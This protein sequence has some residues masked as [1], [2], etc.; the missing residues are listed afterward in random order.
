MNKN[1][2][3][4]FNEEKFISLKQASIISGYAKDYI[5]QLCRGEK[6]KAKKIGRDWFVNS[7]SLIS[8]KQETLRR[9]IF[10]GVEKK[11][12]A[13]KNEDIW[14]KILLSSE[15]QTPQDV[16]K[17]EISNEINQLKILS[18]VKSFFKQTILF[19]LILLTPLIILEF[20]FIKNPATVIA[21]LDNIKKITEQTIQTFSAEAD[22]LYLSINRQA[23]R[24]TNLIRQGSRKVI[25]DTLLASAFLRQ[26]TLNL[27]EQISGQADFFS[28]QVSQFVDKTNAKGKD[29]IADLLQKS[30]SLT[31]KMEE[32]SETAKIKI[33]P[34][35]AS[36][37]NFFS[38]GFSSRKSPS[39]SQ[40]ELS[41][42]ESLPK[43]LF[44][45]KPE[46]EKPKETEEEKEILRDELAPT[47]R[48]IYEKIQPITQITQQIIPPDDKQLQSIESKIQE[49]FAKNENQVKQ[50]A[51]MFQAFSQ[52]QRIN[53]L[54]GVTITNGTV[55]G[56]SGLTDA[57]VPNTITASNYLLL[58]G[59]TLTGALTGTSL[60][61]SGDLTVSGSQTFSGLQT[62][63]QASSTRLSVFDQIWIG[64]TSTTTLRGDGFAS[65]IPFA[66]TTALTVSNGAW[67]IEGNIGIGTTSPYSKLSVVGQI[68]AAYF[69]ATTSLF[70]TFPFASTTAL[71]VSGTASTTNL[72]VSGTAS[73]TFSGPLESYSGNFIIGSS[74]TSNNLLFNPY[75]G[76]VGIASSSP[77]ALLSINPDGLVG[78]SFLV[79]SSTQ[80]NLIVLNS[81]YVGIGT[82]TPRGLLGLND[83]AGLDSFIVGSS[84]PKFI[85]KDSGY[86]GIGTSTPAYALDIYGTLRIDPNNGLI[87]P[88]SSTPTL[89]IAGQI[90]ID[91]TSGQLK[92]YDGI[93]VQIVTG[94]TSPAFNIA[95]TTMG[96]NGKQFRNGTTSILLKNFPE[97]MTLNGFY[98]KAT[99][100]AASAYAG[101]LRFGDGTNWTEMGTCTT[102][103]VET[104]TIT[105]NTFTRFED[106]IVEAS[107][108]APET[109]RM[110]IT[111]I[112]EK[113]AD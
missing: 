34:K 91:T 95:S 105:N 48:T 20:V 86:I 76:K 97:A 89:N 56:L 57:D 72:I 21:S 24:Q 52:S 112:L 84:T 39:L 99:S 38:S 10:N 16:K 2:E 55:S 44:E 98:C 14:D 13:E 17:I 33:K 36:I 70:S 45:R 111:V 113:T 88:A 30:Q 109:D 27:P 12:S 75:G 43:T 63:S 107:S 81:G 102:S 82:S 92:W 64:G 50:S 8:Y 78:P 96:I 90:A 59:G 73:S 22:N 9:D 110:T 65:I 15:N 67:F 11:S 41:Q 19:F 77:W 47:E 6:I 5:G 35:I 85:I 49:L 46:I 18:P 26:T 62:F 69:T 37:K 68:A 87:I 100:T 29:L 4:N 25:S 104:R 23:N 103:G 1:Y 7:D 61:L 101:H 108:T 40:E 106:F 79:G 74:G 71:T 51:G 32:L 42:E 58:T 94:T 54:S 93:K 60:T 83:Y 80:S 3:I 53:N 31:S 66:S 28:E